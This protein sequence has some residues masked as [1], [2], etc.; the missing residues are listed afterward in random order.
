M[1]EPTTLSPALNDTI[2]VASNGGVNMFSE[3]RV[4]LSTAERRPPR[5]DQDSAERR[6]PKTLTAEQQHTSRHRRSSSNERF[7]DDLSRRIASRDA[8]ESLY[9]QSVKPSAHALSGG[10]GGRSSDVGHGAVGVGDVR[11]NAVSAW[12]AI[13]QLA[14]VDPADIG[15]CI[16]TIAAWKR[17]AHSATPDSRKHRERRTSSSRPATVASQSRRVPAQSASTTRQRRRS[18]TDDVSTAAETARINSSAFQRSV[19]RE[20]LRRRHVRFIHRRCAQNDGHGGCHCHCNTRSRRMTGAV[21]TDAQIFPHFRPATLIDEVRDLIASEEQMKKRVRA[22]I[23]AAASSADSTS[24]MSDLDCRRFV[25]YYAKLFDAPLNPPAMFATASRLFE[26]SQE[27]RNA[28]A[29]LRLAL[30]LPTTATTAAIVNAIERSMVDI[31]KA[32][33]KQ[34]K[35]EEM[36]EHCRFHDDEERTDDDG[37]FIPAIRSLI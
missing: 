21:T 19:T 5:S 36:C 30:S 4:T 28:M 35:R 16:G 29:R 3:L 33:D 2:A 13:C 8:H 22:Y 20:L 11:D 31:T 12:S 14:G 25:H 26:F 24:A 37:E 15:E 1:F 6:T 32:M 27:Q 34:R 17:R 23:A 9:A 7:I 18:N 10:G